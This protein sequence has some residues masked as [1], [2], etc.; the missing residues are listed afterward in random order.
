MTK[1]Y[2]LIV[3]GG[4]PGGLTAAKT[5]AEDGLNV[6]LIERKKNITEVNRSCGQTFFLAGKYKGA[7][8]SGIYCYRDP[9][10]VEIGPETN[11][12][13]YP[14]GFA[15]DYKGPLLPY[16]NNFH[17]S[18]SGYQIGKYEMDNEEPYGFCYHKDTFLACLLTAAEKAGVEVW[19][20][21][22]GLS[23]ENTKTGVKVTVKGESG[24]VNLE[25]RNAIAA[26]GNNSRIVDS[27][28]LNKDRPP[29]APFMRVVGYIMEGVEGHPRNC[30]MT[31]CIPSINPQTDIGMYMLA[32]ARMMVLAGPLTGSLEPKTVIDKFMKH[33]TYAHWFQNAR[34]FKETAC[35]T[36]IR[37]SIKEPVVGNIVIVGDAGAPYETLIQG[38]VGCGYL[39][40]KAIEKEH[41]GQDGYIEYINWWQNAFEF[42]DPTF[43]KTTARYMFMNSLCTDEEV[44]YLYTLFQGKV[45]VSQVMIA[46]NLELIKD[47][48]P[49][50]YQ[51]LKDK[52]VDQLGLNLTDVWKEN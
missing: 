50:L 32:S 20:Q 12:F 38:A 13:L 44:D 15:I 43:M 4:G 34:L 9:V 42:N 45:G 28:G 25:A 11:R 36:Q 35:A 49:D 10:K 47:G 19:P 8:E 2:D 14:Q 51:K 30:W 17:F 6:L 52:G 5:A 3:V 23:A 26:D 46:R 22:I 27:L 37:A 16:Y 48:R 7:T 1:E 33:P 31:F 21:T 41:D 40:V 39:A 29:L 18:P 24:E